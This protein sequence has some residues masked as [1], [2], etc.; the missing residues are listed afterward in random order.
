MTRVLFLARGLE[1]WGERWK[2]GKLSE[3]PPSHISSISRLTAAA[4]SSSTL[5]SS[6]RRSPPP[7]DEPLKS[8]RERCKRRI[9]SAHIKGSRHG[10]DKTS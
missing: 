6:L 1:E 7:A 8:W 5:P 10:A 9:K 2:R 4:G 3:T